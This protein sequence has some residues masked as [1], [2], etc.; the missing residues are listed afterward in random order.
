MI[1][2]WKVMGKKNIFY[3]I[4][5]FLVAA[6]I[7][8]GLQSD[9]LAH[10]VNVFAWVDGDMIMVEA[11]FAGGKR[12]MGGAI[13]VMDETG[14][15]IH[16]GK[17][18]EKGSYAF[19]IPARGALTIVVEAGQGH[20]G[21]WNLVVEDEGKKQDSG[22]SA[23]KEEASGER[24][25]SRPEAALQVDAAEIRKMIEDAVGKKLRPL[26]EIIIASREK[27]FS[28]RDI[29]GGIGYIIGLVGLAA[30]FRSK[31]QASK[32]GMA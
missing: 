2:R 10:R 19:A 31:R 25:P 13:K 32:E 21:E 17:T 24:S 7:I 26:T 28:L 3:M 5:V 22:A 8:L 4:A 27:D 11:K 16:E 1:E 20:R 14:K 6:L 29:M 30:Y 9:C 23:S 12:V 18:D 15:L